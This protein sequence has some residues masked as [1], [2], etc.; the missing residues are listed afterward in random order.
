MPMT[1]T[2]GRSV[3]LS[4]LLERSG[5]GEPSGLVTVA[6]LVS[7]PVKS[8]GTSSVSENRTLAPA[9]RF[10]GTF[11]IAP[12]PLATPHTPPPVASPQLQLA[13]L[14]PAG[15]GS[16]TVAPCTPNGPRL[17]TTI[18]AFY[19]IWVPCCSIGFINKS[20]ADF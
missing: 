11:S 16:S 1:G 15:S 13:S 19:L 7:S 9:G 4:V 5:S 6:V 8:T 18:S 12:V 2:S 17:L 10:T 20:F 3:S 14:I